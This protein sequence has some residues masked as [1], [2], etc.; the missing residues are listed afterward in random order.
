MS[1]REAERFG[2]EVADFWENR[3]TTR[4]IGACGVLAV[5]LILAGAALAAGALYGW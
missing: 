1:L 2:T 5:L 4:W 3:E